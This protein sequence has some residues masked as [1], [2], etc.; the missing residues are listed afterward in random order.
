MLHDE[1]AGH[2]VSIKVGVTCGFRLVI[3]PGLSQEDSDTENLFGLCILDAS[4]GEFNLSTFVDDVCGTKLETVIRQ[5][6]P[7]EIL[8]TKVY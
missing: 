3:E 2:L 1:Q 5:L 8:F 6:R 4:T 7:K